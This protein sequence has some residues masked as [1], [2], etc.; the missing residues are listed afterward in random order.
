MPCGGV[1]APTIAKDIQAGA[2]LPGE[3]VYAIS[4]TVVA[5]WLRQEPYAL[6]LKHP[7]DSLGNLES[8]ARPDQ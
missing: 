7:R 5:L 1:V 4:L 8:A 3:E 2:I 6:S